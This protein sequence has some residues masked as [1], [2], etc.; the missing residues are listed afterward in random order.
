MATLTVTRTVTNTLASGS[1]SAGSNT[2]SSSFSPSTKLSYSYE[3]KF[4]N[5]ATGPTVGCTAK[6]QY[7]PDSGT[8]WIDIPGL[9]RVQTNVSN[10]ATSALFI[11]IPPDIGY[12]TRVDLRGNTSQAVTVL[13]NAHEQTSQSI[14]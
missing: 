14:A 7:T 1:L 13:V 4:V 2:Q 12:P 8:T 5:G 9:S 3:C 6:V 10:G 11:P